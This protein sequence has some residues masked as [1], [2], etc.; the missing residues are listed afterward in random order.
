MALQAC[1]EAEQYLYSTPS[2]SLQRKNG[3]TVDVCCSKRWCKHCQRGGSFPSIWMPI[4]QQRTLTS[5][6]H[7][8]DHLAP[9]GKKDVEHHH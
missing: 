1:A 4:A 6:D 9:F 3:G 5:L 7:E 8:L 2:P